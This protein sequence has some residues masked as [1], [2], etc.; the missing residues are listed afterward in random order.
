MTKTNYTITLKGQADLTEEQLY[1]LSKNNIIDS[2]LAIRSIEEGTVLLKSDDIEIELQEE[3]LE[4]YPEGTYLAK[5]GCYIT[6]VRK[7]IEDMQLTGE[8]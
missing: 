1:Y 3:N 5:D 4:G 2:I 7:L 8:L 6:P